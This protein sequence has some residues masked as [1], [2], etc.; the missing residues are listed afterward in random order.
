[1]AEKNQPSREARTAPA[2]RSAT[3]TAQVQQLIR[4]AEALAARYEQDEAR[5]ER[6]GRDSFPASDPPQNY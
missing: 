3:E 4:N 5:V 1:M 6:W 2:V